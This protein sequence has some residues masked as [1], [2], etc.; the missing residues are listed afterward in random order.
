MDKQ[1]QKEIEDKINRNL[2]KDACL[3]H[4]KDVAGISDM[5]VLAEMIVNLHYESHA[6]LYKHLTISYREAAH[7]DWA[8]GNKELANILHEISYRLYQTQP[9]ADKLWQ[10]SKPFMQSKIEDKG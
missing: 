2:L 4:K 3:K 1:F 10:I 6:E 9:L 7:D 8:A 5:K